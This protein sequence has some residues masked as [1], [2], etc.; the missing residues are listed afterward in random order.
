MNNFDFDSN[1]IENTFSQSYI[2][3]ITNERLQ[4]EEQFHIKNYLLEM[5]RSNAKIHLKSAPQK[6]EFE[7]IPA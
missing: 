4:G 3:Y 1:M 5:P 2:S 6:L 7:M